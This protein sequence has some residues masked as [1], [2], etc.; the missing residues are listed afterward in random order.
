MA[1]D[2]TIRLGWDNAGL[3]A[4]AARAQTIVGRFQKATISAFASFGP[5][6][7]VA[8]IGLGIGRLAQ[9]FDQ[10]SDAAATLNAS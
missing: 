9:R 10:I 3:Q 2:G 8:G 5:A 6:L 7:G 4:G 1:D